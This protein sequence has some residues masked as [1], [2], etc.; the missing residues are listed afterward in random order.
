[1][2]I[3]ELDDTDDSDL[4]LIR[5]TRAGDLD[6]YGTLH[7]RHAGSARALAWRM[8]RSP[9]DAD[10][11]V[12]EGFARVLSALQRG[13]GPEIAFRPY[14]L[15]TVR[16]LAY[17]RTDRE[18]RE[19]PVA[20]DLDEPATLDG[21]PVVDGFERD[22]AAAAFAS[23]PE[24]WRMVLWHTEV[25]GQSPAEV[26]DLLGIKPNA[27]A[28]LAYRAREGLRQAYLSQHQPAPNRVR[29]ECR[30]TR[31]RLAAYV[32]G[33]LTTAQEAKVREHLESC[34]DCRAAYLELASVN[35]SFRG[36]VGVGLL[37]PVAGAYLAEVATPT[38]PPLSPV[39]PPAAGETAGTAPGAPGV[40]AA[41]GARRLASSARRGPA[42]A[43]AAAAVVVAVAVGVVL[44]SRSTE[45]TTLDRRPASDITAVDGTDGGATSASDPA[46]G[47]EPTT[48]DDPQAP[49]LTTPTSAAFV[50]NAVDVTRAAPAS[51]VRRGPAPPAPSAPTPP[52]LS[53]T[54]PTALPPTTPPS[55]APPSTTP[56]TTVPPPPSALTLGLAGAGPL[57]AD[58]PGV[59]VV[60]PVNGG[61]GAGR[62]V[63]LQLDLTRMVLRG[64][65][66]F[67]ARTPGRA[68][69]DW[70]C[71][72]P[73]A[74]RLVCTAPRL[75]PGEPSS[76]Y[77]PVTV[78]PG[79]A[80]V[81]VVGAL[82]GLGDAAL[83]GAS[84]T[85]QLPVGD[86][87]MAARFATVDQGDV[88]TIGNSLLTCDELSEGC[89]DARAGLGPTAA[90]NNDAHA[91]VPVDVDADPATA[92]SSAAAW[93]LPAGGEVLAAQLYWAGSTEAPTPAGVGAPD[94]GAV[95]RAVVR[96]PGG[97]ATALAAERV[98][99]V[100]GGRY[101]AVA[102]VTELVRAG[103]AGT[104]TVGGT[105]LATGPATFGG[106]SLVVAYR[107]PAAPVRSLVVLDGL[108]EVSSSAAVRLDVG[109]FT[110]PAGGARSASVDVVAFEGDAGITGDQLAL[111]G[112]ALVDAAN[113]AGNT[114]NASAADRG[115][116][117]PGRT[118]APAN[119]F[120]VDVDRF[121][122]AGALA[123]GAT[124]AVVDL[125]TT[126]DVYLV[127]VVAFAVD[128]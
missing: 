29:L 43:A 46:Q 61:E 45:E 52:P 96:S 47:D 104:W 39:P 20:H 108:T 32:R 94:P 24:R 23:L 109:G 2:A 125:S 84:P 79:V 66:Q 121:D 64:L 67:P 44:A 77:V 1:M 13:R 6:A 65:P 63:R 57:V 124:S 107:D 59:L 16:R 54:P 118:P 87:G 122:A 95:D 88:V 58:R 86:R 56:S 38:A 113:P 70:T 22:T 72:S 110:V 112:Q 92:S 85:V 105:Q 78:A 111:G 126:Q 127:G 48:P 74:S 93:S 55:T 114:F 49:A 33:G 81:G 123:P 106:W 12:S 102:D 83:P 50:P 82:T 116:P 73:S 71:S 51:P 80:P 4:A 7:E 69:T 128:Q 42:I 89:L 5:R 76:F 119:L 103:G 120:G 21:D 19:A 27:V 91:M 68:P 3:S 11:L 10:D 8:S 14:L 62:S 100:G 117:R 28:A 99:Q 34:D 90:L 41:T 40:A 97:E 18:Q 98:D 26:A 25:E 53:A 31:D 35:T 101:Q 36:L 37:G 30:T 60:E 75:D 115:V 15:S 17:D 9:A